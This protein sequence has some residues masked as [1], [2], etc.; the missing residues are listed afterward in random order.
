M[1]HKECTICYDDLSTN[2]IRK[3]IVCGHIFHDECLVK[4]LKERETCPNCKH[5]LTKSTME[6]RREELLETSRIEK[7]KH[8]ADSDE[9]EEK[10]QDVSKSPD[11]LSEAPSRFLKNLDNSADDKS[12]SQ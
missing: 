8:G 12:A 4:W 3:V 5:S 10:Q 6:E 2:I 7:K 11:D 9:E 1:Y